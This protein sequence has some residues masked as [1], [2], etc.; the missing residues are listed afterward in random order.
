MLRSLRS[1]HAVISIIMML[2]IGIVVNA[3][4]GHPLV[5]YDLRV[6]GAIITVITA[7]LRG[8]QRQDLIV[9]SRTGVFPNEGRWVSVFWQQEGG[10]FNLHPDLTWEMDPQATVID[11]GRLGSES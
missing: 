4:S 2:L 3:S 6:N 8:Q 5:T 9:I 10:R 11:V 7:D 1:M